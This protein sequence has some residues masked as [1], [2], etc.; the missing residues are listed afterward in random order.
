MDLSVSGHGIE[1]RF[2]VMAGGPVMSQTRDVD[3]TGI[4]LHRAQK[5]HSGV[6]HGV[7]NPK[8][9][10]RGSNGHSLCVGGMN[11]YTPHRTL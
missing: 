6:P 9:E 7:R 10:E 5:P 4:R 3:S 2:L 11:T 8:G 1:S